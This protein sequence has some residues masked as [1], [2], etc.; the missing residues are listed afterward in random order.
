MLMVTVR[1]GRPESVTPV[2]PPM[3]VV[4]VVCVPGVG[5]GVVEFVGF[6]EVADGVDVAAVEVAVDVPVPNGMVV[7]AVGMTVRPFPGAGLKISVRYTA[8]APR[9]E[10]AAGTNCAEYTASQM[11]P[12]T[13]ATKPTTARAFVAAA[14][15]PEL[16]S[17]F[18][19]IVRIY[20]PQGVFYV[21]RPP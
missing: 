14:R 3:G 19:F 4:T 1:S 7:E 13:S 9:R 6:V 16:L 12:A 15:L 17:K 10:T 20:I 11:P 21:K 5:E 8:A 18:I 2:E